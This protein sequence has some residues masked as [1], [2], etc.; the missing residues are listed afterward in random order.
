MNKNIKVIFSN[1]PSEL[2]MKLIK[3]F[4]LNLMTL[5]K[6]SLI[7]DFETVSVNNIELYQKKGIDNFPTIIHNSNRITGSD[8]I[9]SY[10]TQYVNR[11]NSKILNKTDDEQINDFWKK[12]IGNVKIDKK[13]GKMESTDDDDENGN[14]DLQKKIQEAFQMRNVKSEQSQHNN[15]N[16]KTIIQQPINKDKI[17]QKSL[18]EKPSD[19]LKN[20]KS[21]N[22]DD[23]LMARFF[24]NQEETE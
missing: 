3:F 5:N 7:F 6:T 11:Y 2:N 1:K 15:I 18:D 9:I 12:T 21:G 8:K 19:T 22:I 4:Q 16:K 24:E 17:D 10:L 23:D 13:S 20:L 14:N